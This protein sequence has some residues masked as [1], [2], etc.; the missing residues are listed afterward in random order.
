[1]QLVKKN[2][3]PDFLANVK[4]FQSVDPETTEVENE[5]GNSATNQRSSEEQLNKL[6][7]YYD[8]NFGPD[9]LFVYTE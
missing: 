1:M 2:V 4:H 3:R 9:F 5:H 7:M 6:V 8:R